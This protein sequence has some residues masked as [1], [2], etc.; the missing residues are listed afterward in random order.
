MDI[1]IEKISGSKNDFTTFLSI[2]IL[3]LVLHIAQQIPPGHID[4]F[5]CSAYLLASSQ[6]AMNSSREV[7]AICHPNASFTAVTHTN[8]L[9]KHLNMI[10]FRSSTL[11]H[12]T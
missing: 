6:L 4:T 11:P 1:E 7:G 12:S 9:H 10:W 5:S 3:F 2:I 8:R